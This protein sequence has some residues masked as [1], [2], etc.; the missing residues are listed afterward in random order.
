MRTTTAILSLPL[1]LAIAPACDDN[2][3]AEACPASSAL[4]I[5]DPLDTPALTFREDPWAAYIT[6]WNAGQTITPKRFAEAVVA[7]SAIQSP[8]WTLTLSAYQPAGSTGDARVVGLGGSAW[9][10]GKWLACMQTK[11]KENGA[12]EF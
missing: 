1:I 6:T 12:I 9:A 8:A 10:S 4:V 7:C 2:P 3:G 5:A 11:W